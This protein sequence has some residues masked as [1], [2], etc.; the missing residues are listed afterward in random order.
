MRKP[1]RSIGRG[2]VNIEALTLEQE[3]LLREVRL[4]GM[5]AVYTGEDGPP[6][7]PLM[8][9]RRRSTLPA[10]EIRRQGRLVIVHP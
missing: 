2:R 1:F 9:S 8:R 4:T 7:G 10:S 6:E 3:R 5:G